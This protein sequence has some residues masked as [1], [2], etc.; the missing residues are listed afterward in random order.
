MLTK[1]KRGPGLD[2]V[3]LLHVRETSRRLRSRWTPAEMAER[4]A[5]ARKLQLDLV[6]L[7]GLSGLED[8]TPR[9][10]K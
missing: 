7:M 10:A 4:K 2:F 1:V 8:E 5:M 6:S 3:E 9:K